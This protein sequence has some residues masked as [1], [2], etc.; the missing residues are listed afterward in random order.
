MGLEWVAQGGAMLANYLGQ[1]ETNETNRDIAAE[2]NQANAAAAADANRTNASNVAAANATSLQSVREQMAFQERMSSTAHQR[3]VADLRA[4][5][6]NPILAVNGG[7]ST[8][9]GASMQAE[10]AKASPSVANAVKID[11]PLSGM[12]SS[13]AEMVRIAQQAKMNEKQMALMDSQRAATDS[14]KNKTDVE[15]KVLSKG[16][17]EAD[18]KNKAYSVIKPW[19]DKA[20]ETLN[21]SAD[22]KPMDVKF[23]NGKT[24]QQKDLPWN[25][26]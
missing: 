10:A 8:P 3:E 22:K 11:N 16:I 19:V 4:A 9:A 13:A 5:G 26:D 17:P 25:R 12:A 15:S 24:L 1:R 21:S 7:A 14:Q 18:L 23:K 6:L 2:T 20:V